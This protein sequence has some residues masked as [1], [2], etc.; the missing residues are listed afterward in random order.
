M[1]IPGRGNPGG[2]RQETCPVCWRNNKEVSVAGTELSDEESLNRSFG[3]QERE[4]GY[5]I[6]KS[7][8]CEAKESLGLNEILVA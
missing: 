8:E 2:A 4:E 1:H 6:V 7:H 3:G 5:K